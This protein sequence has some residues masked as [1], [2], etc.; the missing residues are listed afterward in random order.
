MK[1]KTDKAVTLW[2]KDEKL[3][4]WLGKNW[5]IIEWEL[6]QSCVYMLIQCAL[7]GYMHLSKPI[8]LIFN[9][10]S[11]QCM[12]VTPQNKKSPGRYFNLICLAFQEKCSW[13]R[14]WDKNTPFCSVFVDFF[15]LQ[16][17][18]YIP[19]LIYTFFRDISQA[20]FPDPLLLFGVCF[21]SCFCFACLFCFFYW[22][23]GFTINLK[24]TLISLTL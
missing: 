20:I 2:K 10:C 9:I 15:K 5:E 17:A 24:H 3:L 18:T 12:Y 21:C 14:C 23:L 13:R 4:L 1:F 6:R 22:F 16:T 7:H 11:F 8:V 19:Y